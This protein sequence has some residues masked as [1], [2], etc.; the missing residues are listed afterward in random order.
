[1]E[2]CVG[3][4]TRCI[5]GFAVVNA[6]IQARDLG[7]LEGAVFGDDGGFGQGFAVSAAP[8]QF[9]RGHAS[10]DAALEADVRSLAHL[11]R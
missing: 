3:W 4:L 10:E 5:G 7:Q 2:E 6:L 1:M 9:R 11:H 8:L